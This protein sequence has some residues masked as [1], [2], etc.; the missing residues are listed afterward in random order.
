M[1]CALVCCRAGRRILTTRCTATRAAGGCSRRSR[2]GSASRV[3][4]RGHCTAASRRGVDALAHRLELGHCQWQRRVWYRLRLARAGRGLA[5]AG[6]EPAALRLLAARR[7]LLQ[8]QRHQVLHS[9]RQPARS[10]RSALP[11]AIVQSAHSLFH[12]NT[13]AYACPKTWSDLH[14]RPSLCDHSCLASARAR[15]ASAYSV[16]RNAGRS[17][18]LWHAA[19]RSAQAAVP[20][21]WRTLRG[22]GGV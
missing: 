20:H 10:S 19:V 3:P 7:L 2:R 6:P 11:L 4:L 13:N 21:D 5:S 22:L 8:R 18:V 17:G 14:R 16:V 1:C 9:P 15:S 12:S